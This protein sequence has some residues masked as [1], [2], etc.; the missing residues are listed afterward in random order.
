MPELSG[1]NYSET[2]ASNNAAA[3]NGMPEGMAPSGVNDSWR[4]ATGALQR[5]WNRVNGRYA[6]TGS[7]PNYVLT[8]TVALAAYVTGERYSFRANFTCGA[9][10]TLN[11]S[12]LGAKNIKKFV[13]GTTKANL[14]ANDIM[15]GQAVTVEYDGTDMLMVTPTAGLVDASSANTF[16]ASQTIQST[17]AG[18]AI[19]PT[20]ILDR[21]SASPAD[22]DVI[23]GILFRGEDE[24]GGDDDY[25][26]I[27]GEIVDATGGTEDGR[28]G[29]LTK[30]AG[31]EA[32]RAYV[33]A[34]IY[35][36]S[37]T[38]GD[39]G[40]G[41]VNAAGI[42]EAGVQLKPIILGTPQNSTS[43]SNI[44]FTSIPSWAKRIVVS[45]SD[46]S[47]NGTN[48]LLLQLGD[49]GGIET[50]GYTGSVS[51]GASVGG[52]SGG[53]VL[54]LSHLAAMTLTGAVTLTLLNSATNLW[55]MTSMLSRTDS[56]AAIFVTTGVKATSAA[57]DRVRI[58][59]VGGTDAFD[60]GSINILYD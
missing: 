5:F 25:A 35:T 18:A 60:G 8:P 29:F 50:T 59:T 41:T 6:S 2:D 53:F 43:G 32:A 37:V 51:Q 56:N 13:N 48:L 17:D 23:G 33:G 11:I 57:L 28:I 4:A 16:T 14:A 47:T 9:T 44:D 34:G 3:P 38:G 15:S 55:I 54:D 20:L 10:P 49:S 30:I 58:T 31:T 21:D 36:A 26:T 12:G 22:G 40:A 39:Q 27:Q 45:L 42:Y 19:G 52:H 24:S 7:T 1:S 46:V